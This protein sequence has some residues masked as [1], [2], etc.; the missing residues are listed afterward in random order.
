MKKLCLVAVVALL[1]VAASAGPI[2]AGWSC[3]G[4][5][6][7]LGANG[8]VTLSPF[9]NPAYKYVT[10]SGGISGVGGLSGIGGTNGSVLQTSTFG[11]NAGDALDFYFN[12]VTSDGAGFADYGWVKLVN[13]SDLSSIVLFTA[14]TTTSGD[15]VPGFGLPG[16]APGV[17]MVPPS[18]AI[19]HGGPA[20]SP[21]GGYSGA[22]Y[23]VGCGYTGWI[24]SKYTLAA[25][26]YYMQFGVTN[27]IDTIYDTG[28]AIDGVTVAGN[29]IGGEVPEP[30]SIVLLASGLLGLAGVVRRKFAR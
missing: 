24:E 12:Y 14:R 25:G 22:C 2:P 19:I 21:L 9:G 3:T 5:C 1:S 20:W 23:N 11:A 30:G 29:P 28:L 6:G 18:T 7:T 26:N 13:A 4:N 17:T 8:V 15:T 10:T 16:I 27:W